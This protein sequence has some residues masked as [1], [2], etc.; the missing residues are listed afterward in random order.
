MQTPCRSVKTRR[1]RLSCKGVQ[2]SPAVVCEKAH[3]GRPDNLAQ[4]LPL[5]SVLIALLVSH[6][7]FV[8]TPLVILGVVGAYLTVSALSPQGA[9]GEPHAE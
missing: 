1:G 9:A 7:G 6:A 2:D 8:A 3:T 5:S 4:G